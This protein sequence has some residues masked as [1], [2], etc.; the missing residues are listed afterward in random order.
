MIESLTK[1]AMDKS[2]FIKNILRIPLSELLK[3]FRCHQF[4]KD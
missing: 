4:F 3:S 2:K 1:V